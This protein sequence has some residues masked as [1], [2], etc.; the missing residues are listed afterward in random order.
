MDQEDDFLA[1]KYVEYRQAFNET[2]AFTPF[3]PYGWFKPPQ[4]IRLDSELGLQQMAY[5]DLADD[6]ARDL[7]N[8]INHLIGLTMRLDAWGSVIDGLDVEQKNQL[9]HEFVQDLAATALLGPYTLKA[10]FFFAIAHLSHQA[11]RVSHRDEWTDDLAALPEDW[12]IKEEAAVRAAKPWRSWK[13]L[14][15][16]LN[17]V[18]MGDYKTATDDF[19]SKHT[20][21][22]TPRVELGLSQSIKRIWAKGEKAP[23]YGIGGTPPLKLDAVVQELKTQCLRLS[24][25]YAEFQK[26]VAEQSEALFTSTA[27]P[28][29]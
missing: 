26:L 11:N 18:D 29:E 28:R 10:R 6:A 7:A 14:N 5:R 21:R 12:G 15:R 4:T 16:A 27:D 17:T 8:G 25:C 1:S 3:M 19:R 20:H 13:K 24:A 2:E 22:F 9:L 23:S